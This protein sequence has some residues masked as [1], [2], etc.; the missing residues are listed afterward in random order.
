MRTWILIIWIFLCASCDEKNHTEKET[1]ANGRIKYIV[2]KNDEDIQNG[3]SKFYY[4]NGNLEYVGEFRNGLRIGHH[5]EY[6]ENGGL[7]KEATYVI[8]D[9]TEKWVAEKLYGLDGLIE[10]HRI[11]VDKEVSVELIKDDNSFV[12]RDTIKIL[13]RLVNPK[14]P[15]SIVVLGD[16]DKNL[17]SLNNLTSRTIIGNNNHEVEISHSL[18]EG[19]NVIRGMFRDFKYEPYP[20]IDTLGY[21]VAEDSY[22]EFSLKPKLKTTL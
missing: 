10:I 21:T 1:Y 4:E 18:S 11:Q 3:L 13:L 15:N 9:G 16:I 17:R 22:F 19:S 12:S 6:F 8:E 2:E 5:Q 14:Y 20:K 7:K